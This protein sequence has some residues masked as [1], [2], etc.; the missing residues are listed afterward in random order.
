[1]YTSFKS[2]KATVEGEAQVTISI[3]NPNNYF[4]EK[5]MERA[6]MC[7]LYLHLHKAKEKTHKDGKCGE[8]EKGEERKGEGRGGDGRGGEGRESGGDTGY[9]SSQDLRG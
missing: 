1:M 5:E 8:K 7:M 2:H 4:T 3:A 9:L 6:A